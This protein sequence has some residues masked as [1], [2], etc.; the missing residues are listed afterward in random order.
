LALLSLGLVALAAEGESKVPLLNQKILTFCKKAIGKKVG[1]GQCAELAY[2][3]LADSG[4]ESPDDFRD[5]PRAGDYVWGELVYGHK[6]QGKTHMETG[7]RKEVR[8]GDVIQMRDVLIK[9]VEE[10]EDAITTETVDADHHT[11]VVSDVSKDGMTY[12]VIEQ[13]ANELPTV[14]TGTLHLKD[15]QSGYILVYRAKPDPDAE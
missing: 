7:K 3:A 12:E 8:P 6:V 13:N 14:T 11:A 9:H 5:S 2:E 1:N 10:T 4:A 15:M